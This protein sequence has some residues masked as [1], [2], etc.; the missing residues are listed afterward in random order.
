[1]ASRLSFSC[2]VCTISLIMI[3]SSLP[4]QA[5]LS[6][7][8]FYLLTCPIALAN[9]SFAVNQAVHDDPRMAASLIR[10]H[11]HDCFVQG[12]DASILLDDTPSMIGEKTSFFNVN[13]IRGYDVINNIK[14]Q[15]ERLCPGV[16]SCADIVAIAARDASVAA[17]GPTWPV[18][19]G[20]KDSLTASRDLANQ[21]LPRFTDSLQQ[22]TDLFAKNNLSARDM[23]ALSGAH[24]IGKAQCF[25]FRD[26]VNSN[27]SDIDPEFARSL[28][29]DLPCPSNGTG[30]TNLASLDSVTPEALD[31]NYYKN[32]VA[33]QGL[34]QSDQILFSGGS[35]DT[36]VNE[37]VANPLTFASDFAAA[38]VKM[39]NI[40]PLT[41]T[42]GEIRRVCNVVN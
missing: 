16:V 26:R 38:M 1:M 40:N 25:T 19:L 6:N 22:L 18:K 35:T 29:E 24:T 12:C 4:S 17:G 39:G 30:D 10:L 21:N 28:R 37:Y 23:V 31:N 5:L 2:M 34:L 33:K 42:Q 14:S 7:E 36:I 27:A 41:G 13:S 9:I 11:F 15:L 20:R 8:I 3:F 32:L